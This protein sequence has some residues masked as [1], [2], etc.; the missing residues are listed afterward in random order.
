MRNLVVGKIAESNLGLFP[1]RYHPV[2]FVACTTL[3]ACDEC[4][5]GKD[6]VCSAREFAQH[7]LCCVGRVWLF[8]DDIIV[9]HDCICADYNEIRRAVLSK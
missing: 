5:S 8:H 1:S 6:V 9:Q 3:S 7:C 4:K 2:F